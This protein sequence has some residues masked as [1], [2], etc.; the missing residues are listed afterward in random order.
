MMMII[1]KPYY[2]LITGSKTRLELSFI[3]KTIHINVNIISFQTVFAN[4]SLLLCA[5]LC[6]QLSLI[7]L[8][9]CLL[10]SSIQWHNFLAIV[11]LLFIN[12]YTLFK[13]V[14]DYLVAWKVYKA[15]NMIQDKNGPLHSVPN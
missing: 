10:F 11:I 7:I 13:M 9:L 14:R 12:Y 3:F 15:E 2:A 5:M 4:P 1:I 6:L 8:Q